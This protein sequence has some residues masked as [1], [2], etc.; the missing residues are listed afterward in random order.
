MNCFPRYLEYFHYNTISTVSPTVYFSTNTIKTALSI[1]FFDSRP[2]YFPNFQIT[3]L[4]YSLIDTN[5]YEENLL[6]I[7]VLYDKISFINVYLIFFKFNQPKNSFVWIF[8]F[9][10]KSGDVILNLSSNVPLT[11]LLTV[12]RTKRFIT[13]SVYIRC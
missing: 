3:K 6:T 5:S 11:Q 12:G 2:Q 7:C 9:P 1:C 13:R 8:W 10:S 4:F